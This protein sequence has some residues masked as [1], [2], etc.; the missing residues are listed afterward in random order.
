[1]ER[2]I[3]TLAYIILFRNGRISI[4]LQDYVAFMGLLSISGK[5][6]I[7][8]HFLRLHSDWHITWLIVQPACD[9]DNPL[10]M[11]VYLRIHVLAGYEMT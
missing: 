4:D 11:H 8:N 5:L 1:M 2:D 3:K 9:Y 10:A 6:V 7:R